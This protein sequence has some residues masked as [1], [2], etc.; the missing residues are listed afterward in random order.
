MEK[1]CSML[2]IRFYFFFFLLFVFLTF[3]EKNT[4]GKIY[5]FRSQNCGKYP[6]SS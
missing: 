2:K 1:Y 3:W 5:A 6:G 4:D